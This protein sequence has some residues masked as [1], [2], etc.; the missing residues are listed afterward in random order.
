MLCLEDD[1][2]CSLLPTI[3]SLISRFS[4]I[5]GCRSKPILSP[6]G[7]TKLSMKKV[8]IG[9]RVGFLGYVSVIVLFTGDMTC[10]VCDG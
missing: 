1:S 8:R 2:R 7:K 9:I 10:S 3:E 4:A 6:P 5:C